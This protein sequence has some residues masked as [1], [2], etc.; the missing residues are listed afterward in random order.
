M[1]KNK[2]TCAGAS[3]EMIQLKNSSTADYLNGKLIV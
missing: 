1:F 2:S 3:E